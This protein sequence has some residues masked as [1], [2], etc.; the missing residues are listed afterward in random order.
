MRLVRLA[1]LEPLL[2]VADILQRLEALEGPGGSAPRIAGD[3]GRAASPRGNVPVATAPTAPPRGATPTTAATD[4]LW[5]AFLARVRREKIALY[6]TL[7]AG[8]PIGVDGDV[9]RIGLESESM[10]RSVQGRESLEL[11]GRLASE[12]AGRPLR[13]EVGPLP[14]DCQG[15][16]PRARARQ[17]EQETLADP[18]VQAAVEIFGGEVRA[19]RERPS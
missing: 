12:A 2:P 16:T 5:D 19:V 18:M 3:T 9:L 7:A 1:T 14:A 13:V 15:D 11:L 8:R 17:R 6:M 10:R 4:G